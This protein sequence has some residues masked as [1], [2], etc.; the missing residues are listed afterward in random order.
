[1]L[2]EIISKLKSESGEF[3][4]MKKELKLNKKLAN[5]QKNSNERE[6]DWFMERERQK[7][8]KHRLEK[9]REAEKKAAWTSNTF[10]GKNIFD[11][12]ATL[13]RNDQSYLSNDLF[14]NQN[15]HANNRKLF[16]R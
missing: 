6:L 12:R 5:M 9:F 10:K 8:I 4:Q 7:M 14:H 16:M 2:K 3:N 11:N 15:I 13:L 1:M